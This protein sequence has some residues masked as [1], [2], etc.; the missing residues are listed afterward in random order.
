MQLHSSDTQAEYWAQEG[1][2]MC[3]AGPGQWPELTLRTDVLEAKSY[4]LA[5]AR[6]EGTFWTLLAGVHWESR[7]C[8]GRVMDGCHLNPDLAPSRSYWGGLAAKHGALR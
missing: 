2:N 6:K 3:P 8:R 1:A 5:R 7:V 4:P